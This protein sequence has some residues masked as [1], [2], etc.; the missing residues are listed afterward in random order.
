MQLWETNIIKKPRNLWIPPVPAWSVK[1]QKKNEQQRHISSMYFCIPWGI[2]ANVKI[3]HLSALGS[4]LCDLFPS[5]VARGR[6]KSHNPLLQA[7]NPC[8]RA[9]WVVYHFS[10]LNI[11]SRLLKI[12]FEVFFRF[13]WIQAYSKLLLRRLKNIGKV[14]KKLYRNTSNLAVTAVFGQ[15]YGT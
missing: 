9:I 4:W 2:L 10:S 11:L 15:H 8:L 6:N 3:S 5:C 12:R 13:I 14:S 7:D 1:K